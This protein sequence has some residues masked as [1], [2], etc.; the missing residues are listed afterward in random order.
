MMPW[1]ERDAIAGTRELTRAV[2]VGH[3]PRVLTEPTTY[4]IKFLCLEEF[5]GINKSLFLKEYYHAII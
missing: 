5:Y 2:R 1:I 3:G 4:G